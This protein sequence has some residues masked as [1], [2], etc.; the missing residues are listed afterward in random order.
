MNLRKDSDSPP[1]LLPRS[2]TWGSSYWTLLLLGFTSCKKRAVD[3]MIELGSEEWR[4]MTRKTDTCV[5]F[6]QRA[7]FTMNFSSFLSESQGKNSNRN[8]WLPPCTININLR[9]GKTCP[10]LAK[11]SKSHHL[12]LLFIERE[13]KSSKS[14]G[15]SGWAGGEAD[16]EQVLGEGDTHMSVEA[17]WL[18]LPFFRSWFKNLVENEDRHW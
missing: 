3:S 2:C 16:C 15:W 8:L 6:P 10:L 14:S 17:G 4:R 12:S 5:V 13:R 1:S 7:W 9:N 11:Y 18:L